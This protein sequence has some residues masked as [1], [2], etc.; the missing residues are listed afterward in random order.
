MITQFT[1]NLN[2]GEDL[3][4]REA[5]WRKRREIITLTV[6]II[7]VVILSMINIQQ[8]RTAEGVLQTKRNIIADIDRQLDTLKKTGKNI[9]KEDVLALAKLEKTRVLWTKKMLAIGELIP[10]EMAVTFMEYKNNILLLRF[11]SSIK[12]DE[13]EFD[14]VKVMI[15]K[16]RNSPL[17]FRD[18]SELR[19]KEQHR[20]DIEDQSILS[21]S[22]LCTVEKGKQ[23]AR[24]RS[25][26]SRS[27]RTASSVSG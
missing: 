21:F 24:G 25:R 13:K 2:K 19:L 12:R 14:R 22:V 7:F 11:I 6:L 26:S 15:D 8:Y 17:F 3:A 9:S 23:T 18:F 5:R 27:S 4:E 16:L 10:E 1:I 20:G